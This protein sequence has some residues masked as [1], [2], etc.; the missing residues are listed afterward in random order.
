MFCDVLVYRRDLAG[1]LKAA[2][3]PY[4][5]TEICTVQHCVK[6]FGL[7]NRWR[8]ANVQYLLGWGSSAPFRV[9]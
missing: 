3:S 7:S 9:L 1:K 4:N 2:R 8:V 6:V 5:P